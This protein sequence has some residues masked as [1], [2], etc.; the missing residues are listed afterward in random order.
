MTQRLFDV[1]VIGAGP[2]G[3]V[4]ATL[5][6]KA[7]LSTLLLEEHEEA[8]LFVNCT[9]II[10]AEAFSKLNLPTEPILG[11]L[12]RIR[13]FAPSGRCFRYNPGEPLAHVV[14]R[15][16]FDKALADLA[17]GQGAFC[18][19]GY[20]ARLIRVD[21]DAVELRQREEDTHPIRAKAAVIATGFGSNLASQVGLPGIQKTVYGAQAELE[22]EGVEEVEIYLGREIAPEAFAWV[23]P[24]EPGRARVGLTA[25]R[26]A[27]LYFQNFLKHPSLRNRIKTKQPKMLLSPIP[28]EPIHRSVTDRVLVVGE[29]AGQ[30]KTTTQGGIYYGMLC[31]AMAAQTLEEAAGKNDFRARMLRRYERAWRQAIGQEL[32]TGLQLRQLFGRLSDAQIDAMVELGTRDDIIGLVKRLAQFDWHRKLIET[33]L[34]LPALQEVARTGLW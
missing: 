7:G 11:S 33:S 30:V 12:Q 24:L 10:G 22:M 16:R 9:G 28:I 1:V 18:R 4:C 15:H 20:H 27:P 14:S 21:S 6:A 34:K 29:A 25:A 31:A 8:G 19:F 23:V 13:F 5:T 2:A 17:H 3:S 32:K 26:E